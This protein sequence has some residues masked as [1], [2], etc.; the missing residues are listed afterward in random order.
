RCVHRE[1]RYPRRVPGEANQKRNGDS[2][3]RNTRPPHDVHDEPRSDEAAE[4][5]DDPE[6]VFR[7]SH[8]LEARRALSLDEA[9]EPTPLVQADPEDVDDEHLRVRA[10]SRSAQQA[11]AI[12]PSRPS[13]KGSRT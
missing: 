7:G 12:D 8:P 9:M 11:M 1:K 5:G 2:P 13:R 4:G 3:L 6:H 10:A